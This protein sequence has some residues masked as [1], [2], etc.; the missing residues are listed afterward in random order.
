M[1]K[2][3]AAVQYLDRIEIYIRANPDY[4]YLLFKAPIIPAT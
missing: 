3:A 2:A 1:T 4:P